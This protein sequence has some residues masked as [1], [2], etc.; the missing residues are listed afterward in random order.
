MKSTIKYL[1]F[2]RLKATIYSDLLSNI[3]KIVISAEALAGILLLFFIS[4]GIGKMEPKLYDTVYPAIII[5]TGLIATS[6]SFSELYTDKSYFYLTLP[7]SSF[8]KLLSKLIII[9][10]LYLLGI[11]FLLIIVSIAVK[12][13]NYFLLGSQFPIYNPTHPNILN[14]ELLYMIILSIFLFGAVYFKKYNFLKTILVISA[15]IFFMI[16]FPA[17]SYK[18][19]FWE[20][21]EAGLL[22][23]KPGYSI[24]PPSIDI[25]VDTIQQ[26][27]E[28][29][30]FLFYSVT[31]PFF[32]L[33]TYLRLRESE[34]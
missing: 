33:L 13:I 8:E 3:W 17:I 20:Y 29:L 11:N 19:M 5:I 2:E 16:L 7:S 14:S 12:G 24:A 25:L 31:A 32:L 23:L 10:G 9:S 21:Q 1:N 15:P 26:I 27:V 28:I 30:T 34:V 4:V 22:K 6:L 18:L